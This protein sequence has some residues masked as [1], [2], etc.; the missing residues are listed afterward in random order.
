[1]DAAVEARASDVMKA[2]RYGITVKLGA[3]K[4]RDHYFTS[5]LGHEYVRINA[6]YR[7]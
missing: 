2:A 1:M 6:D 5:D 4:A 3:G 7:S